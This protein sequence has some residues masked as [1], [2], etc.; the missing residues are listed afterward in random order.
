MPRPDPRDRDDR[1]DDRPRKPRRR[2]DDDDREG[3][4]RKAARRDDDRPDDYDDL[5]AE[6]SR[7]PKKGGDGLARVVPYR[8]GAALAAYYC[9]VFGLIPG[10]GLLLSPIAFILGVIGFVKARRDP[11][12]RGTGHAIAGIVLGL[13]SI[14]LWIVLWFTVLKKLTDPAT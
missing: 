14:P 7:K 13:I 1:D 2:E 12:A 8:N 9:G 3:R 4:P 10:L 5:P 6:R 11:K